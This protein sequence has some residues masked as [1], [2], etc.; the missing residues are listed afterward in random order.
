MNKNQKEI[1]RQ[2][3]GLKGLTTYHYKV[4]LYLMCEKE[5]TQTQIATALDVKKQNIYKVFKDLK[6]M[7]IIVFSR[8]EGKNSYWK[9]NPS[10]TLQIKGQMK[11]EY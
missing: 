7:D 2:L 4:I 1:I 10:P 5:A 8:N 3:A 6:S 11:L 9:L